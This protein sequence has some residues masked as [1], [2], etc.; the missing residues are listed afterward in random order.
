MVRVVINPRSDIGRELVV[1]VGEVALRTVVPQLREIDAQKVA[2]RLQSKGKL[3][4][5]GG[6]HRIGEGGVH[7]GVLVR[8][9]T[10]LVV[11]H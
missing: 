3:P 6:V 4:L 11:H 9:V 10:D 8:T 1:D 7:V 5:A 2:P